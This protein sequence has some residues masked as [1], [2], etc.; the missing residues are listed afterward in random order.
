VDQTRDDITLSQGAYA[1]KLLEKAGMAECNPALVPMEPCLKLNKDSEAEATDAT[2]YRSVVGCLRYLVHTRPDVS[3][4][5][6]YVSQFME[7]TTT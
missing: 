7:K 1:R 6:D 4:A 3:F 2:F 5:V